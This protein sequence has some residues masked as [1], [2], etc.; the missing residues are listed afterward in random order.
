MPVTNETR[1]AKPST[2]KDGLAWMGKLFALG[3]ASVRIRCEPAY[4]TNRPASPPMQ[5]SNMLS[6]RI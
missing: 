1:N 5:L 6:V 3:K 4:A 2:G